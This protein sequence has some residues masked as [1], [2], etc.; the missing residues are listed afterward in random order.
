MMSQLTIDD[1]LLRIAANLHL[2]KETEHEMLTEI[3][4]HLEEAVAEA[5]SQGT[6]EQTALLKAAEQFGVE[7]AA[8]ELQEV[9]T[10]RKSLDAIA[11]VAVPVL[12]ALVLRWLAFTPDGSRAQLAAAPHPPGLLDYRRDCVDHSRTVVPAQALCPGRLDLLLAADGDLRHFSE[13]QPLVNTLKIY[14]NPL[15]STSIF[16]LKSAFSFS[17]FSVSAFSIL[18]THFHL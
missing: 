3:R 18:K 8:A 9:H 7:E 13:H 14:V 5:L 10:G 6:D 17:D 11:L 12:F 16:R 2:S 4:T 1:V 15:S